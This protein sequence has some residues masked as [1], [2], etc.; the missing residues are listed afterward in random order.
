MPLTQD[1]RF[2]LFD[3]IS[4]HGAADRKVAKGLLKGRHRVTV[5]RA[6]NVAKLLVSESPATLNDEEASRI[7]DEA[8]YDTTAA[9]VSR[10]FLDYKVWAAGHYS[11]PPDLYPRGLPVGASARLERIIQGMWVPDAEELPFK[12]FFDTGGF[13]EEPIQ[14]R[15]FRW[16][17][18]GGKITSSWVD[19]TEK[20]WLSKDLMPCFGEEGD[21]LA[22]AWRKLQGEMCHYLSEAR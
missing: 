7:A 8:R 1:E 10:M 12:P 14:G 11:K 16:Y 19:R 13:H 17:G 9:Y 18:D 20:D 22:S 6:Y 5:N 4:E 3:L 2:S 15:S 21:E